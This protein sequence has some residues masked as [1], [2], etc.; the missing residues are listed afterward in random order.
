MKAMPRTRVSLNSNW[1]ESNE[2]ELSETRVLGIAFIVLIT[3]AY[4][5][6]D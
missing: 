6:F 4:L 2:L 1:N 5:F 3:Y